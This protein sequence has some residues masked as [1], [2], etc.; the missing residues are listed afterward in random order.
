MTH[1]HYTQ[2]RISLGLVWDALSYENAHTHARTHAH[3]TYNTSVS[4]CIHLAPHLFLFFLFLVFSFL[5]F[6]LSFQFFTSPIFTMAFFIFYFF[7]A[8]QDCGKSQ[9][10]R[11]TRLVDGLL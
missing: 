8:R 1:T 7:W 11:E 5:F 10:G 6:F 9:C 4:R 2:T 3:H